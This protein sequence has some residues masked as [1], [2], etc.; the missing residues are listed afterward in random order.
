MINRLV[1]SP[2]LTI[3][4]RNALQPL[5]TQYQETNHL[6]TAQELA[7]LSFLRWLVNS[8]HWSP[9]LDRCDEQPERW[10]LPAVSLTW[11]PGYIA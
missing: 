10:T 1:A 7:R 8:P 2:R 6:F 4:E 3:A 11:M 9:V 5:R